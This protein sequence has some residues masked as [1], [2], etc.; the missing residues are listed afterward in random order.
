MS[1]KR[2]CN[3][4]IRHIHYTYIHKAIRHSFRFS[5]CQLPLLRWQL[6]LLLISYL[7]ASHPKR[8][9]NIWLLSIN[10]F[11]EKSLYL[12]IPLSLKA[13]CCCCLL[14]RHPQPQCQTIVAICNWA[15]VVVVVPLA[16]T[17]AGHRGVQGT[18]GAAFGRLFM[19]IFW[20]LSPS[21]QAS[22]HSS[23]SSDLVHGP[24]SRVRQR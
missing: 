22:N 15:V 3:S 8:S 6:P 19:A 24:G 10:K 12:N 23:S 2:G 7:V 13:R 18:W 14:R 1:A 5:I 17:A 20:L 21:I 16:Y 4:F 11:H 9:L